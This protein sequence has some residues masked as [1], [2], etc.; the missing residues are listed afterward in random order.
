MTKKDKKKQIELDEKMARC[1]P[2]FLP[3]WSNHFFEQEKAIEQTVMGMMGFILMIVLAILGGIAEAS[4]NASLAISLFFGFVGIVAVIYLVRKAVLKKL[5]TPGTRIHE[6]GTTRTDLFGRTHEVPYMV[7]NEAVRKGK[8]RFTTDGIR[9]RAGR[10]KLF[11]SYEVGDSAMQAH[12]IECYD[13]FRKR[14]SEPTP[15]LTKDGIGLLDRRYYY[16]RTRRQQIATVLVSEFA[17]FC[18]MAA[19]SLGG[20]MG[21]SLFIAPFLLSALFKLFKGAKLEREVNAKLNKALPAEGV[22]A[23]AKGGTA[24][25][26]GR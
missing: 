10:E 1:A 8:L 4:E 12:V 15:E 26:C 14:L 23:G 17:L 11:F 3:T 19:G 2:G 24:H 20:V 25:E 5:K 16:R 9:I 7:W 13:D 22:D 18:C 6:Y 21:A